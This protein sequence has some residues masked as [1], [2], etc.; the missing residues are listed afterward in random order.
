M[1]VLT[2]RCGDRFKTSDGLD[3]VVIEIRG[4]TVRLAAN[5]RQIREKNKA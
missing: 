3:A 2:L 1:L 5:A 4:S